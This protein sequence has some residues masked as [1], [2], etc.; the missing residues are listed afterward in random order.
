[1]MCIFDQI[2]LFDL[3]KFQFGEFLIN[4][5]PSF[6]QGGF[7][8]SPAK[9]KILGI[10][11]FPSAKNIVL[12]FLS[13]LYTNI[14]IGATCFFPST[15]WLEDLIEL[16]SRFYAPMHWRVWV[17]CICSWGDAVNLRSHCKQPKIQGG[18]YRTFFIQ[19]NRW[20]GLCTRQNYCLMKC[21]CVAYFT[22]LTSYAIPP[23]FI[24]TK[25]RKGLLWPFLQYVSCICILHLN[26][27][28]H[29]CPNNVP[30]TPKKVMWQS[31]RPRYWS[32]NNN[33][34]NVTF[35]IN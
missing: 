13:F 19:I 12:V 35:W 33:D 20:C 2:L 11:Y 24:I 30:F 25:E 18:V 22:T 10:I 23:P 6:S 27:T 3:N 32:I 15:V 26:S 7:P 5:I 16:P 21:V 31:W 34:V 9:S 29:G 1:M 8:S 4:M 28:M 14:V 17:M